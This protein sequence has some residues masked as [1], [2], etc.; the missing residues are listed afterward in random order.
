MIPTFGLKGMTEAAVSDYLRV[1]FSEWPEDTAAVMP[2]DRL[3]WSALPPTVLPVGELPDWVQERLSV[4]AM[5]TPPDEVEGVGKRVSKD[6]FWVLIP[7]A[8]ARR[9]SK[10]KGKRRTT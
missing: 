1:T 9:E 4:L 3:R 6:I 7:H 10:G 8:D 5:L 2:F